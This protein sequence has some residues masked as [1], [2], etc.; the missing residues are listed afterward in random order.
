MQQ[1]SRLPLIAFVTSILLPYGFMITD[2]VAITK[3][4]FLLFPLW[5][6]LHGFGIVP[7]FLPTFYLLAPI[8]GLIWCLLGLYTSKALRQF[9]A[10]QMDAKSVWLPTISMLMLQI[11][12]TIIVGFIGFEYLILVIPL[13]LHFL[14]VLFLLLI[15]VQRVKQK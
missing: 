13:P 5:I 8:M 4:Q 6:Y 10:D 12:V 14:I 3:N 15:Q 7:H 11:I 9:Y 1:Q 2:S